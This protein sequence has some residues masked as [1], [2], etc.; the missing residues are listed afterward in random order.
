MNSEQSQSKEIRS[1]A[2]Q[3]AKSGSPICSAAFVHHPTLGALTAA[4]F[5]LMRQVPTGYAKSDWTQERLDNIRKTLAMNPRLADMSPNLRESLQKQ[6]RRD[7]PDQPQ[8]S[9]SGHQ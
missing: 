6:F 2:G 8:S 1:N 5:L 7:W 4:E 3:R 9:E